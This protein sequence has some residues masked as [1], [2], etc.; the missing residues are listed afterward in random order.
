MSSPGFDAYYWAGIGVVAVKYGIEVQRISVG[1]E[2]GLNGES[3]LEPIEESCGLN[4]FKA[5]RVENYATTLL[6]VSSAF[7]SICRWCSDHLGVCGITQATCASTI[8][9]TNWF[10]QYSA[11]EL[12]GI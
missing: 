12:A 7:P 6:A 11:I 8:G 10:G 1:D 9:A 5:M 3:I 2:Y 4:Y